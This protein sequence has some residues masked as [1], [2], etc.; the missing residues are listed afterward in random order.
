MGNVGNAAADASNS[1]TTFGPALTAQVASRGSYANLESTVK[2]TTGSGGSRAAG[3]TATI[4]AG[5]NST[6]AGQTVSMSWRT[7]TTGTDSCL[8]SD[9][10]DLGGLSLEGSGSGETAP[11]VL[12]MSYDTSRFGLNEATLAADGQID[13]LSLDPTTGLWENAIDEDFGVIM[14]VFTTPPG[15][16]AT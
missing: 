9:I 13:L 2:S 1:P 10:L 5:S 12:Q 7:R 16:P 3:T 8:G 15:S 6:A 11:Y 4:L 14:A